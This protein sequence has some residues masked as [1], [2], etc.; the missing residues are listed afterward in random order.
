MKNLTMRAKLIVMAI[1]VGLIPIIAISSMS[2]L[3]AK[4]E[5]EDA[6]SKSTNIFSKLTR[7]QLSTYFE[8]R[9]SDGRVLAA[10][11]SVIENIKVFNKR[12]PSDA[13]KR[14]ALE[15]FDAYLMTAH[16]E[17]GYT[18]IYITNTTGYVA[19][20]SGMKDTLQG[21]DLSVRAYIQNTL[22]GYQTWT[23]LFHSD[24]VNKN[25]MALSTPI[26]DG[27]QV[28]GTLSILFDQ[29]KINSIVHTGVEQIGVT[30]DSYIVDASGLLL[31]DTNQGAF[32]EGA[33]LKE[34]IDTE[35]VKLLASSI[36]AND[37]EFNTTERYV[38]YEGKRVYG[39]LSVLKFGEK[40]T[41]LIIE[42]EQSEAFSGVAKLATWMVVITM[43]VLVVGIV[44][45]IFIARTIVNPLR[46]VAAKADTIASYDISIDVEKRYLKRKDEVGHIATSIQAIIDNLRELLGNVSN[47]SQQVAA[48]SEELTATAEQSTVSAEEVATTIDEIARGASEQAE[49]TTDG[50]IQTGD[51]GAVI[52]EDKLNIDTMSQA[53]NIVGHLV[54]D[55]LVL[56]D[57]LTQKTKENSNAAKVVYDSII[58]TNDSATKISEASA[59][60]ASI[61]EQTNLLA[62]NA[63][64][65]AARAG[66]HGR[67]FSVVADEIR[68]LAEQSTAST[69]LIDEIIN[70]LKEDAKVAVE[71][72]QEADEI[73]VDQV[74][75][76]S[77]TE[78]KFKEI[79]IAM[80]DAEKAVEV[81]LEA[82]MIMEDKRNKV[83]AV[84]ENLS[85]VA[86]EN[87][88][89]TEEASAS[90][91][92]QTAS[93]EE[94]ADASENLS[95]LA[96]ELNSLISQ[97]KL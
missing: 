13:E 18:A 81:L 6:V 33:A 75:S 79:S 23:D 37:T 97:F 44:V 60:I 41:G 61:A 62:L 94:I 17:Y 85:A 86:E 68:K 39:S 95:N 80:K 78:V 15:N 58:K 31:S 91:E 88:A 90:M 69:K 20:A 82:S 19:Y 1:V 67:G 59:L 7:E 64:I 84:I 57:E 2:Y 50:A 49:N 36:E 55:G 66:E 89:S 28:V 38:N 46:D 93:M 14:K 22:L 72:M 8:E 24:V 70:E 16:N 12:N 54:D 34:A 53:T 21:A 29:D 3:T 10:S 96:Q 92:E 47:T 25:V 45:V 51:L 87:A 43:I 56:I 83:Q 35:A 26:K 9:E 52:E 74:K 71:K 30:G 4:R 5:L 42:V 32:K 65:E 27:D 77:E 73:T 11:E 76:V 63:A 48:S 40:I